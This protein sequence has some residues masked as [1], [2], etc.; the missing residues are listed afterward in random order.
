MNVNYINPFIEASSMVIKKA[1][2]FQVKLGKVGLKTFPH[3][4]PE[5]TIAIGITG[6]IYGQALLSIEKDTAIQVASSMLMDEACYELDD[7]A[8]S[9]LG[10]LANMILGNT[11]AIF[12]NKGWSIDIS[13]PSVCTYKELEKVH[14]KQN[15]VRIPFSL[16]EVGKHI[17]LDIAFSE[18]N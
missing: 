8:K 1:T 4:R 7:L 11:A 6:K 13:P 15:V 2:G 16:G 10:E 9:A 3:K 14:I 5:I 17:N 18:N 12:D